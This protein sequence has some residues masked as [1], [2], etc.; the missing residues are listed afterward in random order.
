[1]GRRANAFLVG[2][3]IVSGLLLGG[4]SPTSADPGDGVSPT[5]DPGKAVSPTTDP[6]KGVSSTTDPG[7]GVS[8]TTDP[9]KG[10]SPTTAG[11][12]NGVSRGGVQ[13]PDYVL[14]TYTYHEPGGYKITVGYVCPGIDPL[15][16][17]YA[18]VNYRHTTVGILRH[19]IV[20]L[21]ASLFALF[22]FHLSDRAIAVIQNDA[23][24]IVCG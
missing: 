15:P 8:P 4:A 22:G 13:V 12:G 10:V 7:D 5:T 19:S 24:T 23:A 18:Q 14:G 1:M 6:G 3:V 17:V 11:L 21:D 9:G 16:E 2:L 20:N